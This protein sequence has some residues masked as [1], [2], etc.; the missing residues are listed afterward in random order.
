MVIL[1]CTQVLIV[2]KES[3]YTAP[4]HFRRE[5]LPINKPRNKQARSWAIFLLIYLAHC[6]RVNYSMIVATRSE[7]TVRPPSRYFNPVL[8]HIFYGFLSKI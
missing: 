6:H 5:L 4:L 8:S 7:P 1:N 3:I 2:Q